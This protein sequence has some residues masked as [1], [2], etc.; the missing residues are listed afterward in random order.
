MEMSLPPLPNAPLVVL[1]GVVGTDAETLRDRAAGKRARF[2]IML[3]AVFG[4]FWATFIFLYVVAASHINMTRLQRENPLLISPTFVTFT[5]S[6]TAGLALM[7]MAFSFAEVSGAHVN[8]AVTFATWLAGKTSNRK[9]LFYVLAQLLASIAAMGMICATFPSPID[10]LKGFSV[11][12]TSNKANAFF[13]EMML[14]FVLVFVIFT[15]AFEIVEKPTKGIKLRADRLG[16][17]IGLTLYTPNPQS[18]AG[19][20]PLAIGFTASFLALMGGSVS[21]GAFN[22][23]RVFGPAVYSGKWDDQWLYWIGDFLGAA[24]AAGLRKLIQIVLKSGQN[25]LVEAREVRRQSL[26]RANPSN[27]RLHLTEHDH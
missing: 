12:P 1:D 16:R 17:E 3:G 25:A 7:A 20:A 22:P 9:S 2:K 24:L 21:G 5:D 27:E 19:F 26:L 6:F 15:V 13:L 18:K 10:E 14:T 8:P 11:A 23:A 4:E